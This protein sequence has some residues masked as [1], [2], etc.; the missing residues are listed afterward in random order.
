M[1]APRVEGPSKY[2]P[3]HWRGVDPG[4][5]LPGRCRWFPSLG[6]GVLRLESGLAAHHYSRQRRGPLERLLTTTEKPLELWCCKRRVLFL[7]PGRCTPVM[8]AATVAAVAAAATRRP[9]PPVSRTRAELLHRSESSKS[10]DQKSKWRRAHGRRQG[11]ARPP[12][13]LNSCLVV[14][15]SPARYAVK[16]APQTTRRR[17][18]RRRR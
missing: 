3:R 10:A 14:A 2:V 1:L 8:L 7:Q 16:H 5:R 6:D 4:R 17:R 9:R 13:G 11:Y 18:R 12:S 15:E